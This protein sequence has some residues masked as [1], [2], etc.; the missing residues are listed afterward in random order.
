MNKRKIIVTVGPSS[1]YKT[2]IE[3]MDHAGVDIFRINLSHTKL[4][5]LENIIKTLTNWT[6]KIICLDTEGAQLRTAQIIGEPFKVGKD[7]IVELVAKTANSGEGKIPLSIDSVQEVL[8]SGD[9]LKID[10]HGLVIQVLE[11]N[12]EK[13]LARVLQAGEVASN[14][15]I[16]V[17]RDITLPSFTEKDLA[18]FKI[19][20][21]QGIKT[22]AFS[23]VSCGEDIKKLRALFDY[24]IEVISKVESRFALEHLHSICKET[25]AVLID[26]G[27]LS[28]DIAL[29]RIISAQN[30]ILK[31]AKE[32]SVP[33]Y[34]ATNLMENMIVNSK[35][36][37]AEIHDI[38]ATLDSGADGLVLAAETAVGK[39]PVECV[40][41]MS[42]IIKDQAL[43][44][45][46]ISIDYLLS[47]PSDRIIAPHG[48]KLIQQHIVDFD[49]YILSKM[50][51]LE[52]EDEIL[53]DIVQICVG[54]YSPI[55]GFMNLDETHTVLDNNKLLNGVSWTLPILLQLQESVAKTL[56]KKGKVAVKRKKD[57]TAYAV[58][59]IEAIEQIKSPE[60]LAKKWFT[61]TDSNHPGVA[62]F[63]NC[64][65]FIVSGKPYL[66]KRPIFSS[67]FCYE[68]TPRQTRDVFDEFNWHKV[69][70]FHTRNVIHRGHEFIQKEALQKSKADAIFISPVIGKKKKGDFT[71]YAIIKCYEEIIKG[72]FYE[73]Y[74][75]LLGTFNTYSRY[76]GPREAVFTA[77]CRKNYG[78]SSF[79]VGRDHTGVGNFYPP[80]A[81]IK[82]FDQ[83]DIG[84]QIIRSDAA[85]YCK[86]CK[87]VVMSCSHNQEDYIDLSGSKIR[88]S[89]IKGE[90]IPEY[91]MRPEIKSVLERIHS[92]GSEEIL[93]EVS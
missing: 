71:G 64:G 38:V 24:D 91:L 30:Y 42:R 79:V 81:S 61:T 46:D 28:R 16:S 76:S 72:G 52:V 80:D 68:L 62:M 63:L 55:A 49:E 57:K 83:V 1:F 36:T 22:I 3:K 86:K 53:S 48:G 39:H 59:E 7:E 17:D 75:A 31:K 70:G 93:E 60:K 82:I 78:C 90:D 66:I 13:V 19:A 27:D 26:R 8:S 89:L 37:R 69:L 92:E 4:Q 54:T 88:D 84:M 18:A 15:G 58:L 50:P 5:D 23:F 10:F 85:H 65:S 12:Q 33:V 43:G 2:T 34:V 73:P 51:S 25:D 45:K 87:G 32:A 67:A 14:K 6:D 29:E 21:K 9:L 47:L 41:M 40:R 20:K 44:A 77:V 11:S 35:P 74:G 56:P